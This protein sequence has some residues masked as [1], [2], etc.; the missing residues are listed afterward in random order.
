[1]NVIECNFRGLLSYSTPSRVVLIEYTVQETFQ[2]EAALLVWSSQYLQDEL[3]GHLK[4]VLH[5]VRNPTGRGLLRPL[6]GPRAGVML[7]RR[8]QGRKDNTVVESVPARGSDESK[9]KRG[10][11]IQDLEHPSDHSQQLLTSGKLQD[12]TDETQRSARSTI[13]SSRSGGNSC[14]GEARSRGLQ[15]SNCNSN[16]CYHTSTGDHLRCGDDMYA[17]DSVVDVGRQSTLNFGGL[18]PKSKPAIIAR[19]PPK[20][21]QKTDEPRV[22]TLDRYIPSKV[23]AAD[24]VFSGQLI[25]LKCRECNRD[26]VGPS[27]F[28]YCPTCYQLHNEARSL[29]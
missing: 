27:W 12:S 4:A 7:Y 24:A 14:W 19:A 2:T 22:S 18:K 5:F 3:Q 1:M 8:V 11:E 9:N 29:C 17:V 25:N 28:R 23:T 20:K 6:W 10:A 16:V 21:K 26:F 13:D 15:R